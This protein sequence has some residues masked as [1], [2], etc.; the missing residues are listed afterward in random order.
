MFSC[1]HVFLLFNFNF[2]LN[3]YK[4][5]INIKQKYTYDPLNKVKNLFFTELAH[6]PI[7][8]ISGTVCLSYVVPFWKH[9]VLVDWRLLV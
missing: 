7:Q 3:H 8:S 1:F 6:R 2:M 5:R 4:G 9:C